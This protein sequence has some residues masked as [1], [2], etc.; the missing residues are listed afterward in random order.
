MILAIT[1]HGVFNGIA[2][3]LKRLCRCRPPNGGDDP[4]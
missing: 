1:K 2:L 3:G 4:I